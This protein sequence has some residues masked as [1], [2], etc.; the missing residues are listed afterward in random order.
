MPG[1]CSVDTSP[2]LLFL[3]QLKSHE[4]CAQP[5]EAIMNT[6]G[7]KNMHKIDLIE[8]ETCLAALVKEAANGEKVIITQEDGSAFQLVPMKEVPGASDV[9]QDK[10]FNP[11]G[12]W[13]QITPITARDIAEARKEMWHK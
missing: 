9:D 8:A 3:G 7:A 2:M 12:L 10:L 6:I 1:I 4:N 5:L 13:D 11:E